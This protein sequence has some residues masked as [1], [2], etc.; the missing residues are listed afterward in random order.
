ME[1]TPPSFKRTIS[2]R[3]NSDSSESSSPWEKR[4]K[5]LV[6]EDEVLQALNMAGNVSEK[7]D[8]ILGEIKKLEKLDAIETTLKDLTSR[9]GNVEST[10]DK[11][12]EDARAV[13]SSITGMDESLTHL[14]KE[15]EELRGTVEDK[16]K[17]I[18]YLH[19][20][21]LYLES[22]CRRENL[23]FFGVPESEA[24]ASEGKDAVGTIDV[25]RDFLHDV[26]GFRDPKRNMEFQREHRFGKSVRGKRRPILARFLRYQDHE[27]VLRARFELK[28]TEYVILQDFPQEIMKRRRKQMP[29]LKEAKKRGQKVSFSKSEPDKLFID[30]K[31]I[32]A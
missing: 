4:P 30:G 13:D 31:F 25:L 7:L 23:K 19:M 28:D 22:Y 18:E 9:L 15:V 24:S 3:S 21:H 10:I 27:T 29:K 32:S 2:E 14:I 26:L 8:K 20:Q 5:S 17:Q 12:K 6:E 11:M 1:T 16:D